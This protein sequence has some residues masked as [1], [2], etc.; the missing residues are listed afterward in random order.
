MLQSAVTDTC[1]Q[2]SDY[3]AE[4]GLPFEANERLMRSLSANTKGGNFLR[5]RTVID[6]AWLLQG[7]SLSPTQIEDIAMLGSLVELLN[8]AF[9]V[10]DDI[11]D[12]S[13]TRR[14]QPCWY[15]R[16]DV[17]M[18][19]INDGLLLKS[20]IYVILKNRFR[21][22]PAYV[23]L[24]DIFAEATLQ[25]ELGEHCDI[26][27]SAGH[28]ERFTWKQYDFITAKKT[29]FYSIYLP[30]ALPLIYLGM[31]S[32]T[33][34]K[35]SYD[36]SMTM[37]LV[38]QARDDFLDVYGD[39]KVTGK[40][41]TDIQENKCSWLSVQAMIHCDAEQKRVLIDSYGSQDP[42][43]IAKVKA[44]FDAID[45]PKLFRVWDAE[46]VAKVEAMVEGATDPVIRE[47]FLALISKYFKDPRR[48][49]P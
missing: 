11:M 40:V 39:A 19:A 17:G 29:A 42:A 26:L 6:T 12:G 35:E 24:M 3:V 25:T 48:H 46:M 15:R 1:Q 14:G 34:L 47:S 33:R 9:L 22:H 23:D 43:N 7:H 21:D 10:W 8:A 28:L 2:V 20:S 41:G 38:F 31:T 45:L 27:A 44:I 5:G 18:A 16:E 36:I 37:G 30:V 49:L 13:S 32:P 4:M